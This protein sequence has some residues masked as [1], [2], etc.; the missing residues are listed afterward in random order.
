MILK[1]KNDFLRRAFL[2]ENILSD[3]DVP[4]NVCIFPTAVDFLLPFERQ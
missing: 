3:R 4:G 2:Q 1:Y